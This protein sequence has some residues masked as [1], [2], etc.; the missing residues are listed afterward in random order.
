MVDLLVQNAAQVTAVV[1]L[2]LLFAGGTVA[3]LVGVALG[4]V[5]L[6]LVGWLLRRS[7]ARRPELLGS[8]VGAR[9]VLL[10]AV[11]GALLARRPDDRVWIWLATGLAL[12]AVLAESSLRSML[13]KTAT[14][15]VNLPGVPTVPEPPFPPAVLPWVTLGVTALGWCWPCSRRQAGCTWSPG[16]SRC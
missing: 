13:T 16:C 14:V 15:A 12:L 4:L 7:A 10:V 8:Y 9:L 11:A 6:G 1:S 5:G 3:R 2:V